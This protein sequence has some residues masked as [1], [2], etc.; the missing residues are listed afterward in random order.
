MAKGSLNPAEAYRKAQRKKELKK[1]KTER[2]K[3]RDFSLVKKD[4]TDLEEEIGQLESSDG[5]KGRLAELKAELEKVNKK[6]EEYVKEHP[7]QRNL[8]YR[9]HRKQTDG[10]ENSKHEEEPEPQKRNLFNKKGLPRHP[11]RSIYYDAVMN[12]YGVPP[13][14]MPYLERP[15]RPDEMDSEAED[16]SGGIPTAID[17]PP[18]Y[19]LV[20]SDDEIPMPEGPP[21][22]KDGPAPPTPVQL[23]PLPP[24]P[25]MGFP[26]GNIPPPPFSSVPPGWLPPP[27]PPVFPPGTAFFPPPGVP[28]APGVAFPPG[29]TAPLPPPPPGFFPR[30]QSISSMQDPL[31]SIP[32]TT[33]QAHRAN[34]TPT[35]SSLPHNPSLPPKPTAV[36]ELANATV[37]AA[38]QLRDFKKEATAFMPNSLKRKKP[39]PSASTGSKINAAPSLGPSEYVHEDEG[40]DEK[41]EPATPDVR[42]DLVGM[43]KN[44]FGAAPTGTPGPLADVKKNTDDYTKFMEEMSDIL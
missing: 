19:E 17:L 41:S 18:G 11:E 21:P 15:L 3:A 16:D 39:T 32:H 9:R 28:F 22:S 31:S 35:K 5:D 27:P 25:P 13:P 37:V 10:N 42:P 7:E 26:I 2:A 23:F 8:V 33:Y 12:P 36:T 43:L 29:F 4:T 44:Q 24:P 34:P 38:P 30:A 40:E 14:G 20:E 6:K 1:N